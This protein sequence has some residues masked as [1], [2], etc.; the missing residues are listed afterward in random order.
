MPKKIEMRDG[1]VKFDLT[2]NDSAPECYADG[3]GQLM[4]GPVMSKLLL[5]STLGP[6]DGVDERFVN[7]RVV[8]PTA[9]LIEL[10]NEVFK[11]VGQNKDGILADLQKSTDNMKSRL[12][13]FENGPLEG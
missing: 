8:I 1:T 13:H 3:L 7:M 9:A 6:T 11:A 5:Y 10:A 12:A 2:I 4:I